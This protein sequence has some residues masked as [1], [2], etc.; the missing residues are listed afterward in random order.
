[1]VKLHVR[2]RRYTTSDVYF[3]MK[4]LSTAHPSTQKIRKILP[5]KHKY[6]NFAGFT[7]SPETDF[8]EIKISNLS[9]LE[10]S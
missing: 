9:V 8:Q 5:Q 2:S 6:S 4:L 10:F 1:M 7:N 3:F